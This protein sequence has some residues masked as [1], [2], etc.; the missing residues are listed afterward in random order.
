[1]KSK[2]FVPEYKRK[3]QKG[4]RGGGFG[5]GRLIPD[6]TDLLGISQGHHIMVIPRT[7]ALFQL[8][9]DAPGLL[10][11]FPGATAIEGLAFTTKGEV[12]ATLPGI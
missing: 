11:G 2:F 5:L 10:F 8:P 3:R 12:S 4:Y 1:M 9:H 6:S 7:T